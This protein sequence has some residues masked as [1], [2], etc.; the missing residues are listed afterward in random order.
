M[1]NVPLSLNHLLEREHDAL[2]ES[3][4]EPAQGVNRPR[5]AP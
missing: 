5:S 1:M 2:V 4:R 3:R